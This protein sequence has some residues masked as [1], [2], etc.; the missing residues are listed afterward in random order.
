MRSNAHFR[1]LRLLRLQPRRPARKCA[2]RGSAPPRSCAAD[3]AQH[4]YRAIDRLADAWGSWP[5]RRVFFEGDDTEPSNPSQTPL[6][7]RINGL[8]PLPCVLTC[9]L[10]PQSHCSYPQANMGCRS[11][12][13]SRGTVLRN[14]RPRRVR[15]AQRCP[16][17]IHISRL[18]GGRQRRRSSDTTKNTNTLPSID[19]I[20]RGNAIRNHALPPEEKNS[21]ELEI[22]TFFRLSAM[23]GR[24]R[25]SPSLSSEH[26]F[27]GDN[28][29][30]MWLLGRV[31]KVVR[32]NARCL[33]RPAQRISPAPRRPGRE[34]SV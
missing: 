15:A 1:L 23:S 28:F 31:C 2:G 12:Q 21:G 34:V 11:R 13:T 7:Q 6:P 26:I 27:L 9:V 17:R 16:D 3:S 14:D 18:Q 29:G 20:V 5:R 33:E 24:L 32:R 25:L 19:R 30:D 8:S 10:K 4:A 22:S